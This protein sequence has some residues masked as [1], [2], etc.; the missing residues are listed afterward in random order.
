MK[1][2]KRKKVIKIIIP[3]IMI[4]MLIT[5]FFVYQSKALYKT[6]D[7]HNF[8]NSKVNFFTTQDFTYTGNYQ[9]FIVPHNGYYQIE[10]WGASGGTINSYT[11]GL[12]GYTSGKIK[13]TKGEKLYFYLG[14]KGNNNSLISSYNGGGSLTS[15]QEIYGRAG[16]G[17]T[18]VRLSSGLWNDSV[19]LRSRIMVAGAGGGA[20][21]RGSGYGDGNG[22]SGG[23]LIG[24]TGTSVN[25]TVYNSF[26]RGMGGMQNSGGAR[27]LNT[28]VIDY[29][30]VG[31]FGIGSGLNKYPLVT[32]VTFQSGGGSGYYG[33]SHSG[34]GG[35]GGGSSYISGYAGVNSVLETGGTTDQPLHS[36]NTIHYS[37]KY[38][39]NGKM[40]AGINSENG[41]AKITYLENLPAKTNTKLD[42]VRYIKSCI[43]GSNLNSSNGWSELQ[44][45]KDGKN[46]TIGKIPIGTVTEVVNYSYL[47]ITDGIMDNITP[48]SNFGRSSVTGLQCITIDLE[49]TYNLD[50][51]VLWLYWLDGRTFYQNTLSVGLT[52]VAGTTPLAT[53]L[54]TYSGT[55]GYAET[56]QGKRYTAWD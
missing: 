9:E 37:N 3:V 21:N 34:H 56:P 2:N 25:N 48:T 51:I 32:A 26:V 17:A 20:N 23:N 6:T 4:F 39:I 36:N 14:E 8:I 31:G 10:L 19:F 38:F 45:I 49:Q 52:N 12:G 35:A 27:L 53:V 47:N 46:L 28:G 22:G 24:E 50:E 44:T 5:I 54:H 7:S 55:A 13:L 43:N 15:G 40:Q 30:Y 29:T 42:N 41:K 18:D 11:G 1:K 33:G 16:G